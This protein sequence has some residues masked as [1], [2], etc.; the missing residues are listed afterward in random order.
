[1]SERNT[2]E[3]FSVFE[4]R[5][6]DGGNFKTHGTLLLSGYT[7][8]ADAALRDCMD[9]G[10]QFVAEQVGIPSLCPAHW[11]AVGDGPSDFDHAFHEFVCLRPAKTEELSEP[12]YASLQVLMTRISAA[13]RKW[14]VRLSPN[15]EF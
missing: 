11:E 8:E 12:C 13:A 3:K 5:Y 2:Q 15:C 9:W 10:D 7:P 1:M 6:R 4:Y 14:D